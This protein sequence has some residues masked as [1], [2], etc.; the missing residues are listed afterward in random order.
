M[1][2]KTITVDNEQEFDTL[3]SKVSEELKGKFTQT[4]V[5]NVNG[6]LV[7]TAVIFYEG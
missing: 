4:H 2:I 5:T 1:K 3:V 7:Y 6:L